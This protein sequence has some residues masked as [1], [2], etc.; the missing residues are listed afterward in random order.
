MSGKKVRDIDY[1]Y[2]ELCEDLGVSSINFK[3]TN[4][5]LRFREIYGFKKKEFKKSNE[6]DDDYLFSFE[7]YPLLKS[8]L[9]YIEE[10]PFYRKNYNEEKI[11]ADE[12][13]NY[14]KRYV[15]DIED[16][17][18]Y[19]KELIECL[20]IYL[21][22]LRIIDYLPL[23]VEKLSEF[24][25]AILRANNGEIGA[26]LKYAYEELD[27]AIYYLYRNNYILS[28]ANSEEYLDTEVKEI[29]KT[30]KPIDSIL[31]SLLKILMETTIKQNNNEEDIDMFDEIPEE[32]LWVMGLKKE[33]VDKNENKTKEDL[34]LK[35][36]LYKKFLEGSYVDEYQIN[37]C[38][39]LI[40]DYKGRKITNMKEKI[41]NQQP[42]PHE[43]NMSLEE[44]LIYL[45]S[46]KYEI[47]F[48]IKRVKELIENGKVEEEENF[49]DIINQGYLKYIDELKN[50]S[51]ILKKAT[52]KY[53]GQSIVPYMKEGKSI[54]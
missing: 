8:L 26:T 9:R 15:N 22:T 16:Y 45:E 33:Y 40:E 50:E 24:I 25:I 29:N 18:E 4:R 44:K 2:K 39:S 19:L 6:K 37:H 51:S 7:W 32:L 53:I 14:L 11:N 54:K 17:D 12:L 41:L 23:I 35:R 52:N 3:N 47:E 27:K 31:A 46:K 38:R 1:S 36:T 34:L 20:P 21:D 43:N 42:L 10:N 5:F 30:N 49:E 13:G 48:E 28:I